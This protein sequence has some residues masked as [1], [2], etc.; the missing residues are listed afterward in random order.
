MQY[1]LFCVRVQ[2]ERKRRWFTTSCGHV[3]LLQQ[4]LLLV[5]YYYYYTLLQFAS[6]RAASRRPGTSWSTW[7][8]PFVPATTSTS[9]C[10]G[11][12]SKRPS[13][14]RGGADTASSPSRTY[15]YEGHIKLRGKE[16]CA[17][18]GSF[19]DRSRTLDVT[20]NR[21]HTINAADD[22]GTLTELL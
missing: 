3:V 18:I 19:T 7:T 22:G 20:V 10:A 21:Y 15:I 1:A 12:S 11:D 17:N 13:Y 6:S 14:R 9:S 8:P 2:D 4:Q 16:L 5:V